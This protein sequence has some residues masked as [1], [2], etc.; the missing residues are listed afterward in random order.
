M[1]KKTKT[2]SD[3]TKPV[4]LLDETAVK[5]LIAQQ[6]KKGGGRA[7]IITSPADCNRVLGELGELIAKDEQLKAVI[8]A[9]TLEI[10]NQYA[11]VLQQL[12][13]DRDN[14]EKALVNYAT[15]ARADLLKGSTT[16]TAKFAL[17]EI[18]FVTKPPAVRLAKGVEASEVIEKL[19][20]AQFDSCVRTT[21]ELNRDVIQVMWAEVSPYIANM[22]H[23][24][25]EG[26]SIR[27]KPLKPML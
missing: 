9:K 25:S 8:N 12:W 2:E 3:N 5:A 17:G 11:E 10:A 24:S 15:Q 4:S 23:H 26:E 16:K 7:F 22:M 14:A 1:P 27:I 6:K 20:E 19:E 13:A 21:K 18:S